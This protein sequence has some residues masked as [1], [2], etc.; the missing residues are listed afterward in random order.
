MENIAECCMCGTEY[1]CST[2][3]GASDYESFC[4]FL[5]E[6]NHY[7]AEYYSYDDILEDD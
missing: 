6:D 7:E 3:N 5:C 4:S 1:D 2:P